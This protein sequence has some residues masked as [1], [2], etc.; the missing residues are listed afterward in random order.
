M[1]AKGVCPLDRKRVS[2]SA[3]ESDSASLRSVGVAKLPEM[4]KPV[5]CREETSMCTGRA[6]R[7]GW[8]ERA[9]KDA[10]R[11][12]GDP[13]RPGDRARWRPGINNRKACCSRESERSIVAKKSWKLGGAKGPCCG[14]AESEKECAAWTI[15]PLRNN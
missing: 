12:L 6:P 2:P 3:S 11:N 8:E 9:R 10:S 13:L 14:H 7:G 15:V 1:D 4:M 5:T